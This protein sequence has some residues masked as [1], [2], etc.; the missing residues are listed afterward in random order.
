ML[1]QFGLPAGAGAVAFNV[2]MDLMKCS[3]GLR[4]F[5]YNNI[6]FKFR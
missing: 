2:S 5:D 3:L 1:Q 4:D 6:H